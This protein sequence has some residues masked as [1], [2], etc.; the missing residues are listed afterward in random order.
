MVSS[1]KPSDQRH[2]SAIMLQNIV[3]YPLIS[4]DTAR[5]FAQIVYRQKWG[6]VWREDHQLA[7]VD[8]GVH[9]KVYVSNPDEGGSTFCALIDK[10]DGRFIEVGY[11]GGPGGLPE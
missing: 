1:G 5:A 7:V 6:A 11:F 2:G 10:F 8:E 3:S 9:W 4:A